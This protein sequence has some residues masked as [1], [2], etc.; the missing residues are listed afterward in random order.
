MYTATESVFFGGLLAYDVIVEVGADL[1]RLGQ[2]QD[3]E[4]GVLVPFLGNDV[5]TQLEFISSQMA[6]P[7][8]VTSLRTWF[9]D[10]PQNVHL[11]TASL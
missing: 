7:E 8:P 4:L 2:L 1:C 9:S 3:I 11:G 6:A 10:L 5:N